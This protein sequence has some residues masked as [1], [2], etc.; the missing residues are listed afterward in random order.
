MRKAGEIRKA[1]KEAER[2]IVD[3]AAHHDLMPWDILHM[4]DQKTNRGAAV[5]VLQWVLGL[6]D[7]DGP[8][9]ERA[10]D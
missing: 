8:L 5:V 10:P 6:R 3:E 2:Q 9:L 7:D 1:L 4:I